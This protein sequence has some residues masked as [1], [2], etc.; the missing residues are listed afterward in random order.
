MIMA[1]P[2]GRT[3][4]FYLITGATSALMAAMLG[5]S[6]A[7]PVL[8]W[9][10]DSVVLE[11]F[12]VEQDAL[13][14]RLHELIIGVLG[15]MLLL[16][17]VL[18]LH[19]PERKLALLLQAATIPVVLS[20]IEIITGNF[21][22]AETALVLIPLLAVGLLHPRA[23]NLFRTGPLHPVTTSLAA[24]AAVPWAVFSASQVQLQQ[25][26]AAGDAHAAAGHWGLMAAFAALMPLWALIGASASPGWR[27]TGSLTG[28]AALFFGLH[29]LLFPESASA[30]HPG[31]AMAAIAWGAIYGAAVWRR[32]GTAAATG[33]AHAA[34]TTA[35]ST[36]TTPGPRH[37]G[38]Q[39]RPEDEQRSG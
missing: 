33:G 22:V 5:F 39:E 20:V 6:L 11:L 30:A 25:L 32:D 9:L 29:S 27:V 31:W 36:P 34:T 13:A 7:F 26:A 38:T 16:G 28:L 2:K 23:R 14:H 17:V 19:K 1:D 35:R 4:S 12:D 15:W 8:T 24:I 3:R 18:Q 10:P 37:D 21:V